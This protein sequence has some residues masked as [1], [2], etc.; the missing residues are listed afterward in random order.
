ML[1][2][3]R[4][5]GRLYTVY[6]SLQFWRSQHIFNASLSYTRWN[7]ISAS[8]S[9]RIASRNSPL[10]LSRGPSVGIRTCEQWQHGWL[11]PD[12]VWGGEWDGPSHSCVRWKCTC[13]KG[14]GLF[15]A[16]FLAFFGI[17]AL[18]FSMGKWWLCTRPTKSRP[19]LNLGIT[20]PTSGSPH[21]KMSRFAESLHNSNHSKS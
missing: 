13:L 4:I 19:S 10:S 1:T 3:S 2:D 6:N 5:S 17:F 7:I 15:L 11:D 18:F 12:A 21:P 9:I 20:G 16:W 8:L 14:K